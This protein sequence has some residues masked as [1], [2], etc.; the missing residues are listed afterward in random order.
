MRGGGGLTVAFN[1]NRYAID[2]AEIACAA[3]D[4]IATSIVVDV[5]ARGG[6]D[7][8][9]ELAENW[10]VEQEAQARLLERTGVSS[11]VVARLRSLSTRG[12]G[13]YRITDK[14]KERARERSM[15]MRVLLRGEHIGALG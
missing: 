6:K 7:A 1:G 3:D 11:A 13:I 14:S 2:A 5:F 15:E 8:V 12:I 9:L 4:A 10:P